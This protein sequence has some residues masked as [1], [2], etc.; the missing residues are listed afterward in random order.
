MDPATLFVG[1]IDQGTTSSRFIAFDR[2]GN[3]AATYQ[4]EHKQIYQQPGWCEHDANEIMHNVDTCVREALA[5]GGI[6]LSQLQAI[7]IANQRETALIWDRVTGKPLYNA[8]VWHDTRT[9]EIV[10]RLKNGE[11]EGFLG[12]DRRPLSLHYGSA[13]CHLLLGRQDHVDARKRARPA[14]QG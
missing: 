7:G 5:R 14:S 11:G 8:I 10:H 3:I 6:E 13:H 1:A 9:K 2:N 4:I 12:T